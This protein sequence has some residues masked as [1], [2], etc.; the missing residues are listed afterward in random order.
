MVISQRIDLCVTLHFGPG[1]FGHPYRGVSGHVRMSGVCPYMRPKS[2]Q[3]LS[4]RRFLTVRQLIQRCDALSA[5]IF[6][7]HN[8]ERL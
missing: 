6:N 5:S 1:H 7:R 3:P 4:V 2:V 8:A